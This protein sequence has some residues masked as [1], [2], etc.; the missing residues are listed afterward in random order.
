MNDPSFTPLVSIVF[1]T[2]DHARY[3]E[4]SI[5]SCL[6][7]TYRNIE[8]IVVDESTDETPVILERIRNEDPRVRV[9][10]ERC[11]SLPAALNYGFRY[12]RGDFLTWM[13]DDDIYEANAIQI[14]LE[15]LDQNP[16]VGLV[17][18][19][20]LNIDADDNVLGVD[21]RGEPH[22]MD[23]KSVVG[24][25][26]LYRRSVYAKVG[27]YSVGDWLNEDTEYWLRIRDHFSLL[28]LDATLYRYRWHPTT[29]TDVYRCEVI[30][31]QHWT[32][33]KRAESKAMA[34]HIMGTAY[35]KAANVG[36]QYHGRGKAFFYLTRGIAKNPFRIQWIWVIAKILVPRSVLRAK[37]RREGHNWS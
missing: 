5:R 28:H 29:L 24:R 8:M 37:W 13:C 6:D 1:P 26:I 16:G 9:F 15:A 2:R 4:E 23:H 19:N 17:Y 18:C 36:L 34:R 22:E 32:W 27:D 3:I 25:C 11:G 21:T 12:A 20:L 10:Y 14:M 35:I 7:Q 33:A 31:A 30:L